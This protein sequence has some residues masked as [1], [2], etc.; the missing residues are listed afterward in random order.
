MA[1][2]IEIKAAARE[3]AGKEATRAVRREGRVPGVIYGEKDDPA[4]ISVDAKEL[5]QHVRTGQFFNTVFNI[6]VNGQTTRVIPR[7][8]QMDPVRDTPLHVD[9]LRLGKDARINVDIPVHF[10]NEEE[11]PGLKRGGVL[12]IVRHTIEL[13]CPSDAIPDYLTFD[14]AR[15]DIG[16]S[17][18][19]SSITLPEGTELGIADRD[20]TV[21]TIVGRMAEETEE[22]ETEGEEGEAPGEGEEPEEGEAAA[23]G[24]DES[25][26]ETEESRE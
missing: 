23:E 8:V 20:F 1:E 7:D 6:A 9:F 3:R 21:A 11:S 15:L 2:A 10:E 18:H 4:H 22:E 19:I 24:E 13:I 12:N 26:D 14:L 17:I 16:D 5:W 25:G